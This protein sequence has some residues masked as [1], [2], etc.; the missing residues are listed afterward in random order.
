M[1]LTICLLATLSVDM[2]SAD[3]RSVMTTG[4]DSSWL[5][6][7]YFTP[8]S[9]K[10]SFFGITWEPILIEWGLG[11]SDLIEERSESS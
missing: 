8:L 1:K 9:D 5:L 4:I 11:S 10:S 6:I 7:S 2:K 3:S